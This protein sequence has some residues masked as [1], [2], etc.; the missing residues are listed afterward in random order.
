VSL[1]DS[2]YEAVR[3]R[4]G[5]DAVSVALGNLPAAY[6][7]HRF[8]FTGDGDELSRATP[9]ETCVTVGI[10]MTGPPHVGTLVQIQSAIDLQRA[11]FDVQL[12]LADLVVHTA[13]G[14]DLDELRE[15]AGRYRALVT[16]LGFDP[17]QGC[18]RTQSEAVDVLQTSFRLVSGY[19]PGA[20]PA[21]DE[22]TRLESALE[23]AYDEALIEDDT[24]DFSRDAGGLL[25][26]A[27]NLHPLRN[28]YDRVVL[29]LGADNVG[30]ARRIDA[31]RR[32]VGIAGSVVGLYSYLVPGLGDAPKMSKSIP[33][34]SIHVGMGPDA[35]RERVL[36]IGMDGDQPR[37]SPGFRML[38]HACPFLQFEGL[39]SAS[40]EELE[41]L[42]DALEAFADYLAGVAQVWGRPGR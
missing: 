40:P 2:H 14:T 5:Y 28:D 25:L 9:G 20:E 11:G 23:A 21:F 34:S 35:V 17:K 42:P 26:A 19:E 8:A 13:R 12:V 27:D 16:A 29:V 18:L 41:P 10:S 15:L 38:C 4:R 24:T 37:E 22:P 36:E 7:R 1:L 6:C 32:R 30:L 31:L 3:K 39:R 33:G